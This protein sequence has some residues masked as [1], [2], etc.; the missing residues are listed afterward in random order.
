MQHVRRP[1]E[2]IPQMR[3]VYVRLSVGLRTARGVKAYSTV[4]YRRD[5][6]RLDAGLFVGGRRSK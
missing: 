5:L 3:A 4:V 1:L 6:G 2:I